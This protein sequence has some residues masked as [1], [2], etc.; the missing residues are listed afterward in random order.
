MGAGRSPT[1]AVR[2][3]SC[4]V[5]SACYTYRRRILYADNSRQPHSQQMPTLP[6]HEDRSH[7]RRAFSQHSKTRVLCAV[8][9]ASGAK[10]HHRL[11]TTLEGGPFIQFVTKMRDRFAS[12]SFVTDRW[13]LVL[14]DAA[15]RVTL[16]CEPTGR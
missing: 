2:L 10:P 14:S 15:R 7:P 8:R 9:G 3:A 12:A 6:R 11:G 5:L 13:F 1:G 16:P 4:R